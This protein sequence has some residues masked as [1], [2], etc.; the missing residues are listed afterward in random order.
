[1]TRAR[2]VLLDARWMSGGGSGSPLVFRVWRLFRFAQRRII[3]ATFSWL[4]PFVMIVKKTV[5][6][7][8]DELL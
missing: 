6:L 3:D 5:P 2:L 1:M 8:Q 7:S 4:I